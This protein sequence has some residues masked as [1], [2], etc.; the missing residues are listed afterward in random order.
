MYYSVKHTKHRTPDS[1][2]LFLRQKHVALA[3][4]K[5]FAH[6]QISLLRLSDRWD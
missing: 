6:T 3:S 5:L 1:P 4:L 2:I